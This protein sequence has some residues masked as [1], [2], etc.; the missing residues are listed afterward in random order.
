MKILLIHQYF[1]EQ[2]DPG[3]SRF[4]EMT[5]T[6]SEQ[7]HEITV[8]AG[9]IHANSSE[10][11]VEYKRKHFVH[12]QHEKVSVWRCHVSESYNVN[13]L[14]R[15]WGYFSFVCSSI[16]AGLFKTRDK[17]DL[18]LVTSP[19]LFVGITAYILSKFKRIPFVFEIRDLWPESAIDTGV[20][21]NKLIIK[22]AY[23]FEAFIYSKAKLIN[24]LTPAFKKALIEKKKVLKEKVVL[25]PNAAD[26]SLSEEILKTFDPIDFRKKNNLSDYFVITYVGAHGVANH[27][28]QILDTA[29]LLI[30]TN[31]LFQLIGSG[32]Q[33]QM[34]ID[35]AKK[36]NLSNIKF[37][38]SV[39]KKEVFKYIIASDLG[40]SVLKR[41]DTFKT[42]YSNKTFDYMACKKPI[43]LVIDGVSREL[44]EE[45]D[46]GTFAEPERPE[47][48]VAKIKMYLNNPQLIESQGKNGYEYAK[49]HFDR[50]KLATKYLEYLKLVG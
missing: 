9:M 26:F 2:D 34:L 37:I 1:L 23:W 42:I 35:E 12:K 28:I 46:C 38:D 36:R 19:P 49:L 6:W 32:M 44:V 21:T 17:Y 14:G 22:F 30:D 43:L 13:F 40:C 45:A 10:K 29:E 4:N 48:I 5:R 50:E 27:L 11:R 41:V 25:I 7:G 18:I 20:I 15:L 8:L 3:G 39:P 24:V 16:W 33:K 47:D 31:V